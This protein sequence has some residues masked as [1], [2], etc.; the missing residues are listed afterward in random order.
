MVSPNTGVKEE[1]VANFVLLES[2]GGRLG[3]RQELEAITDTIVNNLNFIGVD[4]EVFVDVLF[5]ILGNSEDLLGGFDGVFDGEFVGQAVIPFGHLLSRKGVEDEI[6]N[7]NGIGFSV[8]DW[9]VEVGE[10]NKITAL[11]IEDAEEAGL[12]GEGVVFGVDEDFFDIWGFLEFVEFGIVEEE[13]YLVR[14][15][16]FGVGGDNIVNKLVGVA[17]NPSEF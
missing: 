3:V 12:L 2:F 14:L 13:D 9:D 10:V 6:V 15:E 16:G 11:L 1:G 8:E 4:A 7:G 5:S 17:A